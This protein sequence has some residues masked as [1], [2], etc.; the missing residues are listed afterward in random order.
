MKTLVRK[1]AFSHS[2]ELKCK[3]ISTD[4]NTTT[5]RKLATK[6]LGLWWVAFSIPPTL[7]SFLK[8]TCL[9]HNLLK[10]KWERRTFWEMSWALIISWAQE[11]ENLLPWAIWGPGILLKGCYYW[12]TGLGLSFSHINEVLLFS[13]GDNQRAPFLQEYAV[14]T[15]LE[16]WWH[17]EWE[18]MDHEAILQYECKLG[19]CGV[20][21]VYLNEHYA[22]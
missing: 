19:G 22:F 9:L 13:R 6:W 20:E 4:N 8:S 21:A 7:E 1:V 5:W 3:F 12:E 10:G 18:D 14:R 15:S 17:F 2:T 11:V 16:G